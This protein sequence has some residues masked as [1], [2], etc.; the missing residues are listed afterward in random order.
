MISP[1]AE[2]GLY[3]GSAYWFQPHPTKQLDVMIVVS[4]TVGVIPT[5]NTMVR[6]DDKRIPTLF[7]ALE[8]GSLEQGTNAP[9][10]Q[11]YTTRLYS[12]TP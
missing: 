11:D 8:M 5:A 12:H 1:E 9:L 10:P 7:L 6:K 2:T 3:G 4:A